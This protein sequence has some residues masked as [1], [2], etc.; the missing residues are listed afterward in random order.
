MTMKLSERMEMG[1]EAA[2]WVIERVEELET[3]LA[4][5]QEKLDAVPVPG[6][7][8]TSDDTILFLN[9]YMVWYEALKAEDDGEL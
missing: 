5:A 8:M 4:A 3:A 9:D 6:Y 1:R 7:N 2:P